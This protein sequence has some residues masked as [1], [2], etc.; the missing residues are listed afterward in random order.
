MASATTPDRFGPNARA[1]ADRHECHRAHE[2]AGVADPRLVEYALSS[3]RRQRL[4]PLDNRDE[5][6]EKS[7]KSKTTMRTILRPQR[8]QLGC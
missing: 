3:Q 7:T 2:R 5:Q 4:G 8:P 1:P 6:A